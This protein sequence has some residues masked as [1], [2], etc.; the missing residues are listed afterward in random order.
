LTFPSPYAAVKSWVHDSVIRRFLLNVGYLVTGS[1]GA[2]VLS[3]VALALV[4]RA[5]GPELLGVLA[6]IE[7][8]IALV[9][10]LVRLE[11][12]SAVIKFGSDCL[13]NERIDDFK[14]L[15]K[16]GTLVDIC[17]AFLA[18]LAAAGGILLFG[19]WM[20]WSADMQQ[21]ALF[22][23]LVIP[24]R[25]SATPTAILRLFNRFA[26]FAC[27]QILTASL[28][29]ALVTVAYVAGAGLWAF[30]LISMICTLFHHMILVTL[31]WRE[32]RRRGHGD[33]LWQRLKGTTKVFPGLWAF[34]WSM[35]LSVLIR[36]TTREVDTLIVG[37]VLGPS[38]A[39]LYHV[40]KRLGDALIK[41]GRPI[42]QAIFPDVARLWAR[43]NITHFEKTVW[44]INLVTGVVGV[45]AFAV[46]A[47]NAEL[48][49][50]SVFGPSFLDASLVVIL[51]L[52]GVSLMMFGIATRPALQSMGLHSQLLLV[53]VAATIVFYLVLASAISQVGV[54]SA[55]LAH[56]SFA[57]VWLAGTCAIMWKGLKR[58][59]APGFAFGGR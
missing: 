20:G 40:A 1:I 4:A 47:P 34:I 32:M 36:R 27:Q 16:F 55:S 58:R 21:M 12:W 8:Y 41:V 44:R 49:I 25:L 10:R 33:A 51:Q 17:S 13:E 19:H 9:D 5:L 14:R 15:V 59:G 30:L 29:L 22:Y 43:N 53:V 18:A 11:P 56:I 31:A 24:F 26:V 37:G 7:A 2:S 23:C 52:L 46:V 38:A 57:V 35:N 42:Q 39:G 48:L 54:I 50:E 28:R 3:L 45:L 6:L